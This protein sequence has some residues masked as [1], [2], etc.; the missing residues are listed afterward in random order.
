MSD[1]RCG[2]RLP[3]GRACERVSPHR[4]DETGKV[5]VETQLDRIE[6]KV[7][8]IAESLGSLIGGLV[9]RGSL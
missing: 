5:I 7:D 4:H 9:K 6:A 3:D 8:A 1:D 2:I